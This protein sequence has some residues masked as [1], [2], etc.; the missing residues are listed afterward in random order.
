M[1]PPKRK[2]ELSP[3]ERKKR[4][5]DDDMKMVFKK[6]NSL[7]EKIE[8][9]GKMFLAKLESFKVPSPSIRSSPTSSKYYFILLLLR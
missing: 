6:M 4:K 1:M 2:G 8:E 7:E 3:P 9:Q 5:Y